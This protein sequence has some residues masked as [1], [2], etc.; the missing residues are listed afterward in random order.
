MQEFLLK[1]NDLS[2]QVELLKTYCF[3]NDIKINEVYQDISFEKRQDFFNLLDEVINHKIDCHV[4][5]SVYSNIYLKIL[6][7]K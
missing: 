4:L 6:E 5:S 7:Q 2:N 3:S 1:K